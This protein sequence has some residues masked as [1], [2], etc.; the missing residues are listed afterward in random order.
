MAEVMEF[1]AGDS[2][3]RIGVK[4]M[5]PKFRLKKDVL[6]AGIIRDG[7]LVIPSGNSEIRT[8]DRVIVAASKKK[9]IRKL[10]EILKK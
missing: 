5:D 6:I 9:Q 1:V 8:G 3:S 7:R 4:F 2:F 10:E